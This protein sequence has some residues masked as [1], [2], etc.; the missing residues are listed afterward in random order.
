MDLTRRGFLSA[1]VALPVVAYSALQA[2]PVAVFD[3]LDTPNESA[4]WGLNSLVDDGTYVSN[5]GG[6]SRDTG[7]PVP[8]STNFSGITMRGVPVYTDER[9]SPSMPYILDESQFR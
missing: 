5:Y 3:L 2:T 8:R 7:L 1:L 4:L 6:I 9:L